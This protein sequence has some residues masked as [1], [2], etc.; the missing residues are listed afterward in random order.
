M[1][2]ATFEA[3]LSAGSYK[4]KI[5][6]D[7]YFDS[8]YEE[9]LKNN[10]KLQQ[11]NETYNQSNTPTGEFNSDGTKDCLKI[12]VN[13]DGNISIA[14]LDADVDILLS[15]SVS[16]ENAYA[17]TNYKIYRIPDG[18]KRQLG[19]HCCNSNMNSGYA[20]FSETKNN[21]SK[22]WGQCKKCSLTFDSLEH[23]IVYTDN[24]G[25]TK[26]GSSQWG[27]WFKVDEQKH[28][29]TC[30]VCKHTPTSTIEEHNHQNYTVTKAPTCTAT[31]IATG[32][33]TK[34]DDDDDEPVKTIDH[35]YANNDWKN[36]T[37]AEYEGQHYHKCTV[38]DTMESIIRED[39]TPGNWV[40]CTGNNAPKYHKKVCSR[41]GA[42]THLVEHDFPNNWT[43]NA[44]GTQKSKKCTTCGYTKTQPAYSEACVFDYRCNTKHTNTSTEWCSG[45]DND[46]TWAGAYHAMCKTSGCSKFDEWMWCA[47]HNSATNKGSCP[48]TGHSGWISGCS[49]CKNHANYAG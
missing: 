3:N 47:T 44:A 17:N 37:N 16:N 35:T 40:Q 34:C 31:G 30:T 32:K 28:N 8:Y 33:C 41:C 2:G 13:N 7:C 48:H 24:Y 4:V 26:K 38:C 22:H 29:H 46:H 11:A 45:T 18:I 12:A 23:G 10:S 15:S 5:K 43:L 42:R 20:N 1:A 25:S 19:G 6:N 14:S 21:D 9:D 27:S 49:T 39:H 36:C